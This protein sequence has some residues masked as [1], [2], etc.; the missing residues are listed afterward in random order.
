[1][2]KIYPYLLL[3]AS[4][5]ACIG[6]IALF[7]ILFVPDFNIY[8]LFLSPIIIALYQAPAAYLFYLYKRARRNSRPPD[9]PAHSEYQGK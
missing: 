1:M 4:I 5:L 9:S 2:R 3:C 7:I 6:G 8:W